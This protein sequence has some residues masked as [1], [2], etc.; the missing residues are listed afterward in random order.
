MNM[1]DALRRHRGWMRC[2]EGNA[3]VEFAL[4]TPL[5]IVLL[6]GVLQI[7]LALHVRAT[8]TAAAAE[9]ARVAALSGSSLDAGVARTRAVLGTSLAEG[10]LAEV[11]AHRATESG[12]HV[13]EVN[14]SGTLPLIGMLGPTT[15]QVSGHA[16][17]EGS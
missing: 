10:A 11:T 5:L 12:L 6:L 1:R 15:L 13:V 17:Q 9:G 3:V 14:V 7:A 4:V 2:D 8:L 16:V